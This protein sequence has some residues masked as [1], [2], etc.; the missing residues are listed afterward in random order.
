LEAERWA[1]LRERWAA[2]QASRER[3]LVVSVLLFSPFSV[4]IDSSALL[5]CLLAK[6]EEPAL[7]IYCSHSTVVASRLLVPR[8]LSA[9]QIS[10]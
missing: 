10:L 8:K 9:H 4:K 5:V 3:H 1:A 6:L 2:A 7:S